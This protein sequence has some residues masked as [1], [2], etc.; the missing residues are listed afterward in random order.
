MKVPIGIAKD[1]IKITDQSETG[2]R[3]RGLI[4]P[5]QSNLHVGL[6]GR[7]IKAIMYLLRITM[8]IT[9]TSIYFLFNET[10]NFQM[11]D[12]VLYAKQTES[13]SIVRTLVVPA[14][15]IIKILGCV[16]QKGLDSGGQGSTCI[17]FVILFQKQC[18]GASR[19]GSRARSLA[20]TSI[21][22]V[23]CVRITCVPG[24]IMLCIAIYYTITSV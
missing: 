21:L 10:V 8:R 4:V 3:C 23:D 6:S 18:Y 24:D 11:F 2:I 14:C 7:Y 13:R 1:K 5:D 9:F 15:F 17:V 20:K 12:S 22:P 19:Y 16:D